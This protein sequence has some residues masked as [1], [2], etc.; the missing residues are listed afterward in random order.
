MQ[1]VLHAEARFALLPVQPHRALHA[2]DDAHRAPCRRFG[3]LP[4]QPSWLQSKHVPALL[5]RGLALLL[6][7]VLPPAVLPPAVLPLLLLSASP[8]LLPPPPPPLHAASLH[9][10]FPPQLLPLHAASLLLLHDA[11]PLRRL[12]WLG[13]ASSLRLLLLCR[14][15]SCG[16]SLAG[17]GL[18]LLW[19]CGAQSRPH[20]PCS[21]VSSNRSTRRCQ[22]RCTCSLCRALAGRPQQPLHRR[23]L[24][25]QCRTLKRTSRTTCWLLRACTDSSHHART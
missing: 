1:R 4:R 23:R 16:L 10:A 14:E 17:A 2:I 18:A 25:L 13:V 24:R 9:D 5:P 7:A 6:P 11:F 15:Q 20:A 12:R 21:R 22:R 3:R 19:R 8:P